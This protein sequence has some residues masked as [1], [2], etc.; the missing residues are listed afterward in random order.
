MYCA[1]HPHTQGKCGF[2]ST[3]HPPCRL[4]NSAHPSVADFTVHSTVA[5]TLLLTLHHQKTKLEITREKKINLSTNIT[6]GGLKPVLAP[7]FSLLISGH[8]GESSSLGQRRTL[9]QGQKASSDQPNITATLLTLFITQQHRGYILFEP[10]GD[11]HIKFSLTASTLSYLNNHHQKNRVL[12][13]TQLPRAFLCEPPGLL[14]LGAG[15]PYII[16][17]V[18]RSALLCNINVSAPMLVLTN[19][20]TMHV[21]CLK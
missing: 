7:L 8:Q 9:G 15:V 2:P 6:R 21:K 1:E 4:W 5:G 18:I 19:L 12:W 13:I 17:N 3:A 20:T 14:H 11:L 16:Q 10:A